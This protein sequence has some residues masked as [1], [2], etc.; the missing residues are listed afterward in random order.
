MVVQR[1]M[2]LA[3]ADIDGEHEA[4]AVRQQHLGEAAGGGADVEADMVLDLDRILLQRAGE[5]DAAARDAGVR[6]LRRK[7]GIGGDGLRWP[8]CTGLPSA[9]TRPASI[10]ARARARLSNRPRSTSS[11]SAR[12]RGE[13]SLSLLLAKVNS[14]LPLA[15]PAA[16]TTQ[17]S[18]EVRSCQM[19][20]GRLP[21]RHQSST[22]QIE[23][24]DHH[25]IV[26]QP[27]SSTV[28]PSSSIKRPSADLVTAPNRLTRSA[29]DG[30]I[31]AVGEAELAAAGHVAEFVDGAGI[32]AG[33]AKRRQIGNDG[34]GRIHHRLIALEDRE[35]GVG[36]REVDR[37]VERIEP[38]HAV[39]GADRGLASSD[40]DGIR[41]EHVG[42]C[43]IDL[44]RIPG[45]LVTL[46]PRNDT[47]LR[48]A[49]NQASLT[50]SA[51]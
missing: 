50:V 31:V 22:V 38:A 27:K 48:R 5:L 10:A 25:Q 20:G 4:G 46:A 24:V 35:R 18:N 37:V 33:A 40:L 26:G 11:T 30:G 3:V 41:Q 15:R 34:V 28:S 42:A 19:I 9:I 32:G 14:F 6:G 44:H 29:I 23:R 39:A 7:L 45:S 2:Q 49:C 47:T 17:A 8:S 36:G 12:L 13:V 43:Q 51:L 1:G 16:S 21:R